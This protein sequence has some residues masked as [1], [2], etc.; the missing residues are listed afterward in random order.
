MAEMQ[1]QP[2]MPQ[3]P[4]GMMPG[5]LGGGG[6]PEAGPSKKKDKKKSKA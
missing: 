4:A 5:M 6:T 2:G 1:G 3:M